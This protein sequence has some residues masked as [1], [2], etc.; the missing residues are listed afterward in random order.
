MR[1]VNDIERWSGHM[2]AE[3]LESVRWHITHLTEQLQLL[4]AVVRNMS[5]ALPEPRP[6]DEQHRTFKVLAGGRA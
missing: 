1:L 5:R 2:P 6:P 4:Q 3:D